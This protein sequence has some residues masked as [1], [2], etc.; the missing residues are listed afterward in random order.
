MWKSPIYEFK[1]KTGFKNFSYSSV[2]I[3]VTHSAPKM[4][5]PG[6]QLVNLF[7]KITERKR[8]ASTKILDLGAAR[9][10]NS[11]YFVEKGF[12]VYAAEFEELFKKGSK[13][14][15]RL[16]ELQEYDNFHPIIFP[17]DIYT[18][19]ENFFDIILLLNVPTVMPIPVERLC[20]LLLIRKLLKNNGSFIWYSDPMIRIGKN[21]YAKRYIRKFLDGYLPGAKKKSTETFYVEL[22][23]KEIETMIESCGL[24]IDDDYSEELKK[25][26]YTNIVYRSR[27]KDRIIFSRALKLDDLIKKGTV[28]NDGHYVSTEFMSILELLAEELK[29]TEEGKL[30]AYRFQDIIGNILRY[31]F[32]GQLTDMKIEA[33]G[34]GIR[35]DVKFRRKN[36]KGFFK[37]LEEVYK[38]P[39]P[40]IYIECKNYSN[41][42]GNPEYDQLDTRLIPRTGMFGFIVVR[43]IEDKAKCLENCR[44]R[45]RNSTDQKKIIMVLED[46]D[47]LELIEAKMKYPKRINKILYEKLDEIIS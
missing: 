46:S 42:P 17:K 43:K 38:I 34:E 3:D 7:N 36:K 1:P 6:G 8:P 4:P 29:L 13:T 31:I 24:K 39:C 15:E 9:L 21:D 45:N 22:H 12:Q 28:Q 16:N 5:K 14:E 47:I 35:I 10:R 25:F 44:R 40:N 23:E 26:A 37:D 11:K 19:T 30:D 18:F 33:P 20:L 27:P 32:K 2:K 41:D